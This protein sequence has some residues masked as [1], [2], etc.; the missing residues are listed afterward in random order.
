M[1]IQVV[2]DHVEN[3]PRP[4]ILMGFSSDTFSQAVF[5]SVDED[6]LKCVEMANDLA[7]QFVD[8]CGRA[9]TSW[10]NSNA[11]PDTFKSNE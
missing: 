10:K 1:S 6:P 3:A 5:L 9:V 7:K 4:T 2:V 8:A 11:I